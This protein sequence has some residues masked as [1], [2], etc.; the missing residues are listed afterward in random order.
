MDKILRLTAVI[1][2]TLHV[3]PVTEK[4]ER[5]IQDLQRKNASVMQKI[6]EE[7]AKLEPQVEKVENSL[8]F[9][10]IYNASQAEVYGDIIDTDYLGTSN[11]TQEE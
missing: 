10:D 5:Q 3:I 1:A 2:K 6:Q 4:E 9:D 8:S 11:Q 7:M